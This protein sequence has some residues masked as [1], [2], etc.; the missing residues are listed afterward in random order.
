MSPLIHSSFII[1]FK[2]VSYEEATVYITHIARARS[3]DGIDRDGAGYNIPIQLRL[4]RGIRCVGRWEL[5]L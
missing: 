4:D 1:N 2:E 5:G 3:L